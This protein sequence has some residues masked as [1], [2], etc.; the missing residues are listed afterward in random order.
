MVMREGFLL[1]VT[2]VVIGCAGAAF[3][4][5]A[6]DELLFEVSRF[7]ATTFAATAAI[8]SAVTLFACWMPAR[9]ATAVDP[10]KALRYE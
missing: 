5:R 1:A 8:M 7:D 2:G 4:T 3:M 9:R 6:L 10:L